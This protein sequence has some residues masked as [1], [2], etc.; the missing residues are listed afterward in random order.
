MAAVVGARRRRV[1]YIEARIPFTYGTDLAFGIALRVPRRRRRAQRGL[2]PWGAAISRSAL[3]VI[4]VVAPVAILL[5]MNDLTRVG[6]IAFPQPEPTPL[7]IAALPAVARSS[8]QSRRT[9]VTVICADPPQVR[10]HV[11]AP[12]ETLFSI[13]AR[14]GIAP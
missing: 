4:S 14:F 3:L 1:R 13:A 7:E 11:V 8:L 6:Q 12:G 2:R 5:G 10:A 9:V